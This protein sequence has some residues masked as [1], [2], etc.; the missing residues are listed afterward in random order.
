MKIIFLNKKKKIP[1]VLKP[2]YFLRH[3]TKPNCSKNGS[4]NSRF[5]E[6]QFVVYV[7]NSVVQKQCDLKKICFKKTFQTSLR[8][9]YQ[10]E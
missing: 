2:L 6:E 10:S 7:S 9:V 3:V 5:D 8:I 1:K 4:Y